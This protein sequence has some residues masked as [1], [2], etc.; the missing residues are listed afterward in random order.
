MKVLIII[1]TYN[2]VENIQIL[3]K[4]IL[5]VSKDLSILVIDD[6]SP[7]NTYQTVK[8]ISE[9]TSNVYVIKRNSKQGLASAYLCGFNWGIQK[10]YDIF[11]EMDA[12]LSHNPEYLK[13]MIE[14]IKTYDVVI[15]SRNVK[16]GKTKGWSLFRNVISKFGSLYSRFILGF[17]PIYDLT[18]GYNMWTINALNKININSINAKGY[19]FQIEMKY[20]AFKN[21]CKIIEIPIT[22][23]DRKYGKSKMDLNIFMEAFIKIWKLRKNFN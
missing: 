8:N 15:G 17:P 2:E 9:M 14:K 16:G 22:F 18:G 21:G 5:N 4:S 10:G 19:L 11:C 12:D 13:E 23:I 3:I 6:N 20:K 1:P 7:D